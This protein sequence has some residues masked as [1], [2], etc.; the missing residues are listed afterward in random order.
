MQEP[1]GMT[2]TLSTSNVRLALLATHGSHKAAV[3]V[4]GTIPGRSLSDACVSAQ[5]RRKQRS[6]VDAG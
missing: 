3:K 1:Y 6:A 5:R 2:A 4:T